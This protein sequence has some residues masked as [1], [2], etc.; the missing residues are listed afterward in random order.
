MLRN[1]VMYVSCDAEE[2]MLVTA[3]VQRD[4]IIHT[5]GNPHSLH[6][7][8]ATCTLTWA[9]LKTRCGRG[10]RCSN[11]PA[12]IGSVPDQTLLASR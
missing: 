7:S 3:A 1:T 12:G 10:C 8:I 6:L 4:I 9:G 11:A 2:S 5:R